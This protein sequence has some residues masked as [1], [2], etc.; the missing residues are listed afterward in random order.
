VCRTLCVEAS[1]L[2]FRRVTLCWS[3]WN[4]AD[5][6]LLRAQIDQQ[7]AWDEARKS[8]AAAA[9]DEEEEDE[10]QVTATGDDGT[11]QRVRTARKRLSV[12]LHDGSGPPTLL[13]W[14]ARFRKS[15][16]FVQDGC[17]E[18]T[19]EGLDR[20][21]SASSRPLL[22]LPLPQIQIV[23]CGFKLVF[24]KCIWSFLVAKQKRISA[25]RCAHDRPR[26]AVLA[27]LLA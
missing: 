3:A 8:A 4:S 16:I 11:A 23:V 1:A 7:T 5:V 21:L 14:I 24:G 19:F 20:M 22:G 17:L 27:G 26:R 12:Q 25:D 9:E 10:D 2:L 6:R 13:E 15:R 18:E